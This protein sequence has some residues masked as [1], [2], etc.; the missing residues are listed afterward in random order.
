MELYC[1]VGSPCSPPSPFHMAL[2]KKLLCFLS[3]CLIGMIVST[4]SAGDVQTK[5]KEHPSPSS[6]WET[7]PYKAKAKGS[8]LTVDR[9]K[10]R[11]KGKF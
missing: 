3:C 6:F 4:Q 11:A 7:W 10:E 9:R 8:K 2:P 1:A 5:A